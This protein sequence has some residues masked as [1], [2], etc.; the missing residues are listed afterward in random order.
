MPSTFGPARLLSASG[1][2]VLLAANARRALVR[3]GKGGMLA[4]ALSTG[5]S[6]MP[7]TALGLQAASV[8]RMV[9][10]GA[11]RSRAG[12]AALGAEL[13]TAE[14]LR[15]LHQGVSATAG[16]V[17]SALV[18]G[19]G[20]DYRAKITEAGLAFENR[21]LTRRQSVI[22]A[23]VSHR[24]YV[25]H[26]NVGYGPAGKRNTLD[27]WRR[28]RVSASGPAPVLVQ[29][30][31][32]A[33]VA[34]SNR[35][36]AYPLLSHLADSGWVCVAINYRLSPRATWP[37][38]V[39]DV[40]RAIA[41]VRS[42]I[43]EYGGD[44][45]FVVVSGGSAGG[46]LAMLAALS[47][48]HLDWQPGFEAA[49]TRVQA[50]VSLYGVYDLLNWDGRGGNQRSIKFVASNVMKVAP[51]DDPKAWHQ[52]SPVNWVTGDAPPTMLVHGTADSVVPLDM[53]RRMAR[54]MRAESA[55]PVVYAEL[56]LAQHAFDLL[57]SVRTL[58]TV[59]AIE[60]FLAF[61]RA[62]ARPAAAEPAA[63]VAPVDLAP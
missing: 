14:V 47:P 34:G 56:P 16:V 58:H 27:I 48:G 10:H 2:H 45:D 20:R 18:A 35:Q 43:G 24:R 15:E 9:R 51:G 53:A 31:G 8:S 22:P 11:M 38:H 25:R 44:P 26:G 7:L 4:F 62:Q 6:E 3:D 13:A 63:P 1:R 59:R 17:E 21:P 54:Q 37:D 57:G 55:S 49:D 52:A 42:H 30:H 41:W 39:V 19:L 40:K 12:R 29:V 46:H 5:I 36:Q 23:W 28:D 50:A 61:V 60:R 32:G 33:W